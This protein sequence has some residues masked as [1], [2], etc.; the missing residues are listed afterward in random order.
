M[1]RMDRDAERR[2]LHGLACEWE[3]A[4]ELLPRDLADR[5]PRPLFS[6]ADGIRRL[7]SWHPE[8]REIRISRHLIASCP[9]DAVRDVLRHEM[10]HQL[11]DQ[12]PGAGGQ[13][14]HGPAFRRACHLLRADPRASGTYPPLHRRVLSDDVHAG[15]PVARRIAKLL[16]L[17]ASHNPHE[18]EAAMLKAHQLM[19]AHNIQRPP[20]DAGRNTACVSVFVGAPALRHFREAYLLGQLLSD[21][22]FVQGIWVPAYVLAKGRLGRVL[23]INGRPSNVSMA[24]YVHAFVSRFIQRRWKR[25]TGSR[26]LGSGR[27]TDFAMGILAAF[28]ERLAAGITPPQGTVAQRTLIPAADGQLERYLAHRY[29]HLTTVRRRGGRLDAAVFSDG[30]ET[31]AHLVI[32]KPVEGSASDADRKRLPAPRPSGRSP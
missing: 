8:R 29:P 31:G 13:P 21:F 10:A 12:L 11:A 32:H 2:V 6:L 30:R 1:D 17:A 19:A 23:E 18:A 25:Y 20:D 3:V 22:Y 28:R 16:A 9:W 4:L 7:G 15:G 27:R 14:P 24:A 5:L 26:R